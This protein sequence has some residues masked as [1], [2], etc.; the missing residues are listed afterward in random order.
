MWTKNGFKSYLTSIQHIFRGKH[1]IYYLQFNICTAVMNLTC[2]IRH[3]SDDS[4][5]IGYTTEQLLWHLTRFPYGYGTLKSKVC[6]SDVLFFDR[7]REDATADLYLNLQQSIQVFHQWIRIPITWRMFTA[8]FCVYIRH[9][10]NASDVLY[11]DTY[12]QNDATS[13]RCQGQ[14]LVLLNPGGVT[15]ISS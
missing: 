10:N 9:Q 12:G 4:L 15:L 3:L 2:P 14:Y 11:H 13:I 8:R 7:F 1:D 5:S 6:K